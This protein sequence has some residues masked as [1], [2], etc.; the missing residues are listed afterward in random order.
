LSDC[1]SRRNVVH[2]LTEPSVLLRA[3]GAGMLQHRQL[4]IRHEAVNL[5]IFMLKEFSR[6]AASIQQWNLIDAAAQNAF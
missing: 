3:I 6:F 1:A 2:T 4:F 5:L